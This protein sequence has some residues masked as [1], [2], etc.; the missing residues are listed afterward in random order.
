[1]TRNDVWGENTLHVFDIFESISG[2]AGGFLQGSWTTF[3]RFQGCNLSCSWC[4]APDAAK[5]SFTSAPMHLTVAEILDRVN[6]F[7]NPQVL[8]TGGEPLCQPP[9]AF[10][11]LMEVLNRHGYEI[12]IETNGTMPLP[13]IPYAHW[14]IDYKCPSSGIDPYSRTPL[15]LLA[16]WING[17]SGSQLTQYVENQHI[18][19]LKFVVANKEDVEFAVGIIRKFHDYDIRTPF[20]LSPV[21]GATDVDLW[22]MVQHIKSFGWDGRYLLQDIVFSYQLHK[23]IGMK[24]GTEPESA[25]AGAS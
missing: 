19:A 25:E 9:H 21:N 13:F 4:D 14:V 12:Q 22:D 23:L 20:L 17:Y 3:I 5:P 1:M 7:N 10:H 11:L 6:K 18:I 16:S 8:I 2:E 15:P 24:E